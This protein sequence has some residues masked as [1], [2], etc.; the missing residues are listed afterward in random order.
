MGPAT[1]CLLTSRQFRLLNKVAAF[2]E[3]DRELLRHSVCYFDCLSNHLELARP[4]RMRSIFRVK[5]SIECRF[6]K[7]PVVSNSCPASRERK[8]THVCSFVRPQF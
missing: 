6:L 8:E 1:L 4:L 7:P 2:I 3:Q 5:K